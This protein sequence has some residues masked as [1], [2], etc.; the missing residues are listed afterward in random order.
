VGLAIPKFRGT[1]RIDSLQAFPLQYH[2]GESQVKVDLVKSG[3][4]FASL[5]GVNHRHCQGE[6]FFVDEG[7]A[8]KVYVDSRIMIDAAFFWKMKPNYIRLYT[9][10]VDA[11]Y[12]N[13][14]WARF[15]R[16]LNRSSQNR[17]KSNRIE[18]KEM[19][20]NDLLV[21]GP[22]VFGFSF[23]NQLWGKILYLP[24]CYRC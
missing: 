3:R 22:T 1:K 15:N 16:M 18:L 17:V 12:K 24:S 5:L 8:I 2:S 20:E 13:P 14:A 9:N 6:A 4:K 19:K 7:E 11:E 10:L 21:C 23:G